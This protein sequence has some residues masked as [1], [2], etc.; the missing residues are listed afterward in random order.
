MTEVKR[1]ALIDI[2]HY[3][4]P[5][6]EASKGEAERGGFEATLNAVYA[7][8]ESKQYD[9][10]VCC[11]DAPPYLRTETYPE[12]KANRDEVDPVMAPLLA[13]T[14][15]KLK[16]NFPCF[17]AK[18]FEADDIIATLVPYALKD[19]YAVDIFTNDKDLFQLIDNTV[20][21]VSTRN[22]KV[23]DV[24]ACMEKFVKPNQIPD[25][26]ALVGDSSDNVPGCPDVGHVAAVKLLNSYEGVADI[27]V[28]A[29]SARL[30]TQ[31]ISKKQASHLALYCNQINASLALVTLIYDCPIVWGDVFN[32]PE[33]TKVDNELPAETDMGNMARMA[34]VEP[35]DSLVGGALARQQGPG[36]EAE[37]LG[38]SIARARDEIREPLPEMIHVPANPELTSG[39]ELRPGVML[40]PGKYTL[41]TRLA[42]DFHSSGLYKQHKNAQGIFAVM[43]QGMEMD[44]SPTLALSAFHIIE[45]KPSPTASFLLGRAR[46]DPDCVYLEMEDENEQAVTYVCKKRSYPKEQRFTYRLQDAVDDKLRWATGNDKKNRRAMLRA[47]A[48]SQAARLY[49]PG[50]CFGLYSLEE[51]QDVA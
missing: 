4:R 32:K 23:Y 15:K 40:T 48:A 33:D 17:K 10:I 19:G 51:M 21:V 47:R 44:M 7:I 16:E 25:Y 37:P 11:V 24:H 39:I 49:F 45:G 28:A 20:Q 34:G 43:L 14:V 35:S 36:P 41:M 31:G 9:L 8:E 18:G 6:F 13:R 42:Q 29:K 3:F 26:L 2:A 12:Y 22:G 46:Q 50:A 5:A 38:P 27:L 1:I 30:V